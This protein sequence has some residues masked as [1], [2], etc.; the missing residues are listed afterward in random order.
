MQNARRRCDSSSP[1]LQVPRVLTVRMSQSNRWL[2]PGG[3]TSEFSAGAILLLACL[4]PIDSPMKPRYRDVPPVATKA[5]FSAME[6]DATEWYKMETRLERVPRLFL[7]LSNAGPSSR[8]HL[9][10][11]HPICCIAEHPGC[12]M[13][14]RLS[15]PLFSSTTATDYL[16]P[17][18]ANNVEQRP[19]L[20]QRWPKHSYHI[21]DPRHSCLSR[22]PNR[23]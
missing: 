8:L 2:Q 20:R 17:A 19:P 11:L 5:P 4:W 12:G 15:L 1:E 7:A 9:A 14:R 3:A 6:S 21:R 18:V 16:N 23:R 22:H 10:C 13:S